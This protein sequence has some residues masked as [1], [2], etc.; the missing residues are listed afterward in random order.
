MKT[1]KDFDL[2]D[3]KVFYRPDYNVPLKDGEIQ[4]DYR[5]QATTPTLDYLIDQGAKIIIGCHLGRPDGKRVEELETRPV[6]EHLADMYPDHTVRL[7]HEIEGMEVEA[8][9]LEMKGGDI[10]LLPNLR[11]YAE[12]EGNDKK[13]AA[14][15]AALADVYVNDAFACDHR[16][17]ASIVGV[18]AL[19]PG[20]PGFLLE[21]ELSTLGGLLEKPEHPF[22]VIMGG[23]KVSDKI[24]VI[25]ALAKQADTLL[26]GGAMANTFLLAKGEDIG[27]SL[28][29]ADKVDLA[30][31]LIEELGDKLVLAP[32]YV[33]DDDKA[34]KFK[35]MDIG[36]ESIKLF[37]EHLEKAKTIFW[38]GS[39]GYTEDEKFKAASREIAECVAGLKDVTSVVAGG[40]TDEMISE[41]G[42]HDKFSFISTGGG[43]ALEFL[44][45]KELPG[46]K[47]LEEKK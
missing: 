31:K 19:I 20:C 7:A 3:K 30:K 26:I 8:A 5:I 39:L 27:D 11:F 17:H 43:A 13:F 42:L 34:E 22:V 18:P 37:K 33:K 40:D 9:I 28:A 32:D 47:A 35:Y 16:A 24:E 1:L 6:A 46:V 41:L 29:E 12:E 14:K 10:L 21:N 2:K 15:L 45:G 25:Q 44:A 36:P 4:D 23:A 38:N